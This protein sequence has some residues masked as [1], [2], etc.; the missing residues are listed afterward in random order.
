MEI[1]AFESFNQGV[2]ASLDAQQHRSAGNIDEAIE[3][4]ENA[5]AAFERALEVDPDHVA[6]LGAMG[7]SLAQLGRTRE[8][9]PVFEQAIQRDPDSAENFRQLGLCQIEL[10]DMQKGGIVTRKAV[11]LKDT[12]EYRAQ[13]ASEVL[14]L[15][16]HILQIIETNRDPNNPEQ[17]MAYYQWA[18]SAFTLACEIDSRNTQARQMLG[19]AESKQRELKR[20]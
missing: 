14:G 4:D 12:E 9:V 11:A 17:E 7:M 16:S 6:A 5:I 8:A 10:G 19:V 20:A 15:G 3:C 13:A 1:D 18:A 2:R